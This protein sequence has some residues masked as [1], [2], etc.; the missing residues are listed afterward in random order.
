MA[1]NNDD[2]DDVK[3]NY[4]ARN[5][6]RSSY[7]FAAYSDHKLVFKCLNPSIYDKE[8]ISISC[9]TL[10]TLFTTNFII[11]FRLSSLCFKLNILPTVSFMSV[12]IHFHIKTLSKE[13]YWKKRAR[14]EGEKNHL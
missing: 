8:P 9:K 1:Y 10:F 12:K 6:F 13:E 3:H 14:K 5:Y 4:S 2:N 7:F 11:F